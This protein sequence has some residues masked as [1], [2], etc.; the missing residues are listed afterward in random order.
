MILTCGLLML[1]L[2]D[3]AAA[4]PLRVCVTLP[5]L[6][7][8]ARE[9]GGDEVKVTVFAKGMENPHFVEAKPSFVKELSKADLFIEGGLE[10][11]AAWAPV[12]LQN[13][14]NIKVQPDN[15]GYLKASVVVKPLE[16][17]TGTIDRSRG[18]VHPEGNPHYLLDP[19]N[20]LK[21]ANLIKDRLSELRPDKSS[22]FSERYKMFR[23]KM[24]NAMV[25]E[26]L[27]AKHDMEKLAQLYEQGK[28]G[29]FLKGRKEEAELG[30]W[31]G[32]MLP[33]AGT[34]V[35]ADHNMWPYFASRFRISVRGF[36][37]PKPGVSP[38][39]SHLGKIVTRM[40]NEGVGIVIATPYFNSKSL[41][42]VSEKGG[43]RIVNLAHQ[44][45]AREGVDDYFGVFDYNINALLTALKV[46]L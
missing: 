32:K 27:A 18:D 10:L 37:E 41:K 42:F 21:V 43:A 44:V 22:Y 26:K 12:L 5:D 28:L 19:L 1:M 24:A 33:Y 3:F 20:G 16:V 46:T 13:A 9:I 15:P 14:R 45:G 23:S 8:L 25:G 40:R 17:P 30:G 31:L 34:K 35:I 7:S 6:G 36:L 4:G 11:E 29:A 2:A 39:T 38:S